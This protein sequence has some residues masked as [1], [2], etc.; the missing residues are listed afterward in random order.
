M[1]RLMKCVV[2]DCYFLALVTL[3]TI[4]NSNRRGRDIVLDNSI[5][6][7]TFLHCTNWLLLSVLANGWFESVPQAVTKPRVLGVLALTRKISSFPSAH[8]TYPTG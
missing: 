5:S 4:A 1:R 7:R 3:D 8:R 6:D 2:S